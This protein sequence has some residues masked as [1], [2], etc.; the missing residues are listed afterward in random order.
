MISP[1][2]MLNSGTMPPSGMKLSCIALTAPHEAAVV[3]T[4]KSAESAARR[5]GPPCPPCCR[6][7]DAERREERVAAASAQ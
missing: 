6:P 5:S 3:I 1:S 2:C 7:V 4:A